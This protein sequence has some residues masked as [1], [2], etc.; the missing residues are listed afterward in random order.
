MADPRSWQR[1]AVWT[2]GTLVI[3]GVVLAVLP[4]EP[5]RPLVIG[6]IGPLSGTATPYGQSQRAGA[7][8]ALEQ[9]N[10]SAGVHGRRIE[11]AFVDDIN[12]AVRAAELAVELIYKRNVTAL[13]GCIDSEATMNLQP[14]CERAGV[15]LL[16]TGSTHPHVKG[17]DYRYTFSSIVDDQR[18]AETLAGHIVNRCQRRRVAVVSSTSRY[19][20]AGAHCVNAALN[21]LG[22]TAV[23]SA[24]FADGAA[25]FGQALTAVMAAKPDAIVLWCLWRDAALLIRQARELGC[26]A[27]FFG[28]DGLAVPAFIELGGPAVEGTALV[29]PFAPATGDPRIDAFITAYA[30]RTGRI[31]DGLAAAGYDNILRLARALRSLTPVDLDD[32]DLSRRLAAALAAEAKTP[33]ARSPAEQ[34]A[35]PIAVVRA[36]QLVPLAREQ[37][38]P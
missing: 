37:E 25:N 16:N 7:E 3:L 4:R 24:T 29:M 13:V 6:I 35:I 1:V 31:P 5:K 2:I 33:D 17:S 27:P 30:A 14:I 11:A 21:Q 10:A 12:N 34:T 38:T 32:P 28:G 18:Q 26:G 8:L 15:P 36:G 20:S 9:I 22:C 23:A 19:G